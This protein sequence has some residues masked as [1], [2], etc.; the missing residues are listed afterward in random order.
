MPPTITR[1]LTLMWKQDL[2][3]SLQCR[4]PFPSRSTTGVPEQLLQVVL[5]WEKFSGTETLIILSINFTATAQNFYG[6]FLSISLGRAEA[7]W[8]QAMLVFII[9]KS[10]HCLTT[11]DYFSSPRFPDE[12]TAKKKIVTLFYNTSELIMYTEKISANRD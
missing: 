9:P 1:E 5:R 4:R 11:S 2:R 7:A 6:G 10:S 8:Q 12:R 3:Y